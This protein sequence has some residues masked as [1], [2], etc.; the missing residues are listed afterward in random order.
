MKI[1]DIKKENNHRCISFI[2]IKFKFKLGKDFSLNSGERQTAETI[3][4]IREDHIERYKCC[5][6]NIKKEFGNKKLYGLDIF[7]GVGYG[8]YLISTEMPNIKMDAY[9]GSKEA[10]KVANKCYKTKNSRFRSKQYPFRLPKKTYDFVIS[11]ESIEHI[12]DDKKFLHDLVNSLK[13]GGLLFISCPNENKFSLITNPIKHHY[14]HYTLNEFINFL[15][16]EPLD[17]I[18]Y[19]GHD[20]YIMDLNGKIKKEGIKKIFT[21][22]YSMKLNY[23][24]QNILFLLRRRCN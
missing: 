4:G 20:T 3:D 5:I 19:Y 21:N 11:I 24:G 8:T 16:N 9:D 13:P 15:Q 6:E 2:G 10:I 12:K 1:L 22:E 17:L 18:Q 23:E 14:R 7:C